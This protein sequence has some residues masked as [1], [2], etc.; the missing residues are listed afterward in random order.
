MPGSCFNTNSNYQQNCQLANR[1]ALLLVFI[2]WLKN[3]TRPHGVPHVTRTILDGD[4]CTCWRVGHFSGWEA[5]QWTLATAT[6]TLKMFRWTQKHQ[7][8]AKIMSFELWLE[9]VFQQPGLEWM[10]HPKEKWL[11]G[12]VEAGFRCSWP[13]R[14][15]AHKMVFWIAVQAS[16]IVF[17][18][19]FQHVS[20]CFNT[21][22]LPFQYLFCA[23]PGQPSTRCCLSCFCCSSRP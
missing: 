21:H 12:L 22:F 17:Q 3:I 8:W 20:T 2:G 7:F 6:R 11:E 1:S 13:A 23:S 4:G 19:L 5:G 14:I 15:V 18:I 10:P 9:H 16:R